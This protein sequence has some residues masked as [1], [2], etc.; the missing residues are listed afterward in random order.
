MSIKPRKR[1]KVTTGYSERFPTGCGHIYIQVNRDEIGLCEV[2][3]TLGKTGGCA[4]A[5]LEAIGRLV[6]VCLRCAV[7]TAV[8]VD[9][10]KGIR[11]PSPVWDEGKP[12]DDPKNM[13]LS[14]ADAIGRVLEKEI[15]VLKELK[16]KSEVPS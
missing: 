4:C 5:Q 6:S 16:E 9:H 3:I 14:C 10:L 15:P 13:I 8:L 2:F 7:D 12:A 11:C 1:P